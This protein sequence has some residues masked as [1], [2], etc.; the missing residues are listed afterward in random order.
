LRRFTFLC[1]F[2]DELASPV[3]MERL[4]SAPQTRKQIKVKN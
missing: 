1:S 3:F 4:T 2:L